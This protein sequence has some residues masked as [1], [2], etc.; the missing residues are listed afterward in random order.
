MTDQIIVLNM[1]VK[2]LYVLC[3]CVWLLEAEQTIIRSQRE[4]MKLLARGFVKRLNRSYIP[5]WTDKIIWQQVACFSAV[6]KQLIEGKLSLSLHI[7]KH[8]RTDKTPKHNNPPQ[9]LTGRNSPSDPGLGHDGL[10]SAEV[11]RWR[12]HLV[13]HSRSRVGKG[14]SWNS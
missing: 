10:G 13:S 12:E 3:A 4:N 9:N 11:K 6:H 8:N 2:D 7:C 14:C 5:R 1:Y